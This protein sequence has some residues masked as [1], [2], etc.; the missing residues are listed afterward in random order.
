MNNPSVIL[1][2][3]LVTSKSIS[4]MAAEN[5]EKFVADKLDG[6][7]WLTW[8]YQMTRLL[9]AKGLFKY[10][11]GT[12][13]L[14]QEATEEQKNAFESKSDKAL[15]MI[16]MS[17]K[18]A[19][20]YLVTSC[21]KP[22][23]AW[24]ALKNHFERNTVGNKLLLKKSYFRSEMTESTSVES[25]L[26]HMKELADKLA[27]LGA[28]VGEDDQVATLL[29]SLPQSYATLV[30][31]LETRSDQGLTL[32]FVQRALLNEEEKL[33]GSRRRFKPG[34]NEPE[35]SA[36]VSRKKCFFC[37][38]PGHFRTECP[39]RSEVIQKSLKLHS[40]KTVEEDVDTDISS[41]EYTFTAGSDDSYRTESPWFIDSGA[42]RHMTNDRR[43]VIKFIKFDVAEAVG[44]G[45][46]H[47][48]EAKGS[49]TVRLQ[50]FVDDGKPLKVVLKDVLYVPDLAYNLFSV[51]SA[52]RFGGEI[53]F[54][55]DKCHIYNN[56]GKICGTGCI[57]GKL[58][59]LR[60]KSM[61]HEE[62]ANIANRVDDIDLW[63]QRMGHL[64]L[65]QMKQAVCKELV[66]GLK[67]FKG[68]KLSFCT[69]CTEGKLHR[70][71]FIPVGGN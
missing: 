5:V 66:T 16:T 64:N 31:A 34:S 8:K 33:Q 61:S 53:R 9:K 32:G 18:T 60:C 15:A 17:I 55:G 48:V 65:Q 13:T 40:A 26:K 23:D 6:E 44:L 58:Y 20:L 11:D 37:K 38:Q 56:R 30:T 28:P 29:G 12:E 67:P 22:V 41:G 42:S 69:G 2:L 54:I 24:N 46:G 36:M 71:P 51:R 50:T 62:K 47:K 49:G 43:L 7:N 27:T 63:H 59:K 4:N 45:D 21:D 70:K 25:H 39:M 14:S 1:V 3:D 52:N 35:D 68:K 57:C 10:V 19:Q